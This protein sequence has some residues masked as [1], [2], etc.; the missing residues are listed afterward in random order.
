MGK[1]YLCVIV[2]KKSEGEGGMKMELNCQISLGGAVCVISSL[3][4]KLVVG[5]G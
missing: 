1:K 5:S 3:S 4:G 2:G